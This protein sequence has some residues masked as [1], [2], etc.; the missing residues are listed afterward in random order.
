M[1]NDIDTGE[2]RRRCNNV[3][4]VVQ[5]ANDGLL[6]SCV[7]PYEEYT[8]PLPPL[9]VYFDEYTNELEKIGQVRLDLDDTEQTRLA[10]YFARVYNGTPFEQWQLMPLEDLQEMWNSLDVYYLFDRATAPRTPIQYNRPAGEPTFYRVPRDVLFR[11][12]YLYSIEDAI[13]ANGLMEIMH[14]G[15]LNVEN[16]EDGNEDGVIEPYE[17]TGTYYY[18]TIGSGAALDVGPNPLIAWNK[19][20]ALK[21]MGVSDQEIYNISGPGF[22]QAIRAAMDA[23][24]LPFNDA[25]ELAISENTQ[26][27]A[28]RYDQSDRLVY[29]GL[30]DAG[31]ATLATLA[32]DQGYSSIQLVREAQAAP[33]APVA[34]VGY[35]FID[36]RIP[37]ESA[38][39]MLIDLKRPVNL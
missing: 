38:A 15:I 37:I 11:Q 6:M 39:E 34:A 26:G 7:E 28:V 18:R 1:S 19:V 32:R 22:R 2:F 4:G 13:P 16:N 5:F 25:L 8:D 9:I 23:Y 30:G 31:D 20:H 21:Q 17:F 12:H 10:I 29:F 35:E 14:F 3:E 24:N 33:N 27:K 36:L